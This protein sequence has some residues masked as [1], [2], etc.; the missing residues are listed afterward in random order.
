M[1]TRP[2]DDAAREAQRRLQSF[3]DC[4]ARLLARRWIR[5]NRGT[6]AKTSDLGAARTRKQSKSKCMAVASTTA[7]RGRYERRGVERL[8]E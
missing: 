3:L 5:D 1:S 7:A 8:D 2:K 6:D 4:I